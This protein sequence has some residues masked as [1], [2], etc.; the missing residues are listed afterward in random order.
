MVDIHQFRM[1]SRWSLNFP[2]LNDIGTDASD[3]LETKLNHW[4]RK[5]ENLSKS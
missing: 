5:F 3:S 4:L 1:S 2:T